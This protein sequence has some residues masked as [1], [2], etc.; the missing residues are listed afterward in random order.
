MKKNI[1]ILFALSVY[2]NFS[3]S[4][5]YFSY[6][7][8]INN[9]EIAICDSLYRNATEF[10]DSAFNLVKTPF[11]KDLKNANLCAVY[12][13]DYER[14]YNYI[15]KML[16][17]GYSLDCFEA[18]DYDSLKKTIYWEKLKIGDNVNISLNFQHIIKELERRYFREQNLAQQKDIDS[19]YYK[20]YVNCVLDNYNR[21]KEIASEIGFPGDAFNSNDYCNN[22]SYTYFTLLH[23]YQLI[24]LRSKLPNKKL[25][26]LKF[27]LQYKFDY[28]EIHNLLY[29]AVLDGQFLPTTF[30]NLEDL[31]NSNKYGTLN[32]I[33]VDDTCGF[34]QYSNP[35]FINLNR[36]L[37]GLCSLQNSEI[38]LRSKLSFENGCPYPPKDKESAV[39]TYE[40]NEYEKFDLRSGNYQVFYFNEHKDGREFFNSM[41]KR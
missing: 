6:Y 39:C 10:Y 12:I 9:A 22:T 17:I 37:I 25:E 24:Q 29:N 19:V 5:N 20:K 36:K 8:N 16:S 38:I 33:Q 18:K 23:Y 35:E 30:A 15:Q 1:I 34:I 13:K 40:K 7:N 14:S 11:L 31:I 4:Q 26:N 2:Y 28:N 41:V 32:F 21:I 27:L 3:Y